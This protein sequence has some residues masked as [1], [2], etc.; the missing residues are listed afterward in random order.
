VLT[1]AYQV[2]A[3]CET[4]RIEGAVLELVEA[5]GDEGRM[6]EARCRYCG[7]AQVL[8]RPISP[9]AVPRDAAGIRAAFVRWANEEGEEVGAFLHAHFCGLEPERVEAL[10]L[11][12]ER[13]PTSFD[14]VGYLFPGAGVRG[15]PVLDRRAPEPA[16]AAVVST[17]TARLLAASTT[18]ARAMAALMLA[19]GAIRPGERQFLDA[20]L[21]RAGHEPLS[22]SDLRQWRPTDL[23]VP[24]D[25]ER[26]VEAMVDL[27]VVDR[28]SDETEWRVV[29]EFA[30]HWGVALDRVETMRAAIERD[31]AGVAR[32]LFHLL[33][34]LFVD[35]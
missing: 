34:S 17:A 30:R 16:D 13:V 20:F 22:E 2:L 3:D 27:M 14:V 12:R 21:L 4:C 6:L 35:G 5:A 8:G 25:P 32:R 11:A 28:Q 1:S 7:Y 9:G 24:D 19:D 18:A 10:L 29:R 26:I 33:R 31:R 15:A 23:D